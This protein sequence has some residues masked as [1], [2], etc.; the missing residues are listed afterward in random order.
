MI[1][2][3]PPSQ[4]PV[5]AAPSAITWA[6]PFGAISH[7][8]EESLRLSRGYAR[9]T[10]ASSAGLGVSAVTEETIMPSAHGGAREGASIAAV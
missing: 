10:A 6:A 1:N 4:R 3:F 2:S 9:W 8:V 7:A 5:S